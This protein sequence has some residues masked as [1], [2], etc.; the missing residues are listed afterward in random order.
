VPSSTFTLQD[1]HR[2][3]RAKNY[4]AWQSRL[5][6]P[7]LG[8]RVVEVGCGAGNFT[9]YL[10]NREFVIALDPEPECI[11]HLR[12]KYPHQ[13]NLE[14]VTDDPCSDSFK[15]LARFHPDSC[16][17]TNVLEHIAD[18]GRA[19]EAMARILPSRGTMVLWVPAFQSLFGPMDEQLGHYRR[20]RQQDIIRLAELAKLKVKKL[21]YV[22][23][24]GFFLWGLSSRLMRQRAVTAQQ[25]GIFDSLVAPWL[26]R[27]ESVVPPPFGQTLFAV[28]EKR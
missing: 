9:G 17:C 14:A 19:L 1:Q 10:L 21:H 8:S 15:E 23:S 18:H 7:E 20:Y 25:I 13:S 5:I 22:N 27:L 11:D 26:S 2:M 4:L 6:L 12:R 24:I 28:L 3:A 16:V